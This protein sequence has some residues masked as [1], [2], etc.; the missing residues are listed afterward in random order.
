[1][2]TIKMK[3]KNKKGAEK[4]ISVY[5]FAI[6]ILVAGGI[7][8]M[9]ANFHSSLY[10]VRELEAEI[11]INL[12]SDCI[13]QG[14]ILDGGLF[15]EKESN[16]KE[17]SILIKSNEELKIL[18]KCNLNFDTK[19]EEIQ[20]YLELEFYNFNNFENS[21]SIIFEGNTNLKSDCEIQKSKEYGTISKCVEKIFYSLDKDKNQ[22]F[23]KI[24][25][26]IRK[27]EKNAK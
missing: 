3:L 1:M 21:I 5:W 15:V 14:G 17:E 13:S 25:S 10:D 6:L 12:V 27:T 7:F 22:F 4:I 26:I 9:V 2:I 16:V 18:E 11:M 19:D 8:V 24:L 20:Y 23:V